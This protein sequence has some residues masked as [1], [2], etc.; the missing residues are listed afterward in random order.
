MEAG[1]S[2]QA[3]KRGII[4]SLSASI[5]YGAQY[6]NA[7]LT[8]TLPALSTMLLAVSIILG[9]PESKRATKCPKDAA[10]SSANQAPWHSI[11]A[12][13]LFS[14]FADDPRLCDPRSKHA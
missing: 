7:L 13:T 3:I 8:Q 12:A 1:L 14:D 6:G 10:Q 4:S 11:P 2:P 5:Y 9:Y